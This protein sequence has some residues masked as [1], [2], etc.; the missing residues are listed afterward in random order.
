VRPGHTASSSASLPTVAP[1]RLLV[2]LD[3]MFA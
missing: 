1:P 2:A 3:Q